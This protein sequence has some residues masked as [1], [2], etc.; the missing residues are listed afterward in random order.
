MNV[1]RGDVQKKQQKGPR[2]RKTAAKRFRANNL[3]RKLGDENKQ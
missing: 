2:K 3:G 1:D